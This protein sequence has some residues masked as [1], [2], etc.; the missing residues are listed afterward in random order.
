MNTREAK[1]WACDKAALW[2]R[3]T[4]ETMET[5]AEDDPDAKRTFTGLKVRKRVPGVA[6]A[7]TTVIVT[8]SKVK[9]VNSK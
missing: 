6:C 4:I 9:G 3:T 1:K 2:L 5:I 8:D 7:G